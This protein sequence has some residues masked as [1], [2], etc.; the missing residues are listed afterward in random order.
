M[1]IAQPAHA[2]QR[3]YRARGAA[4]ITPYLIVNDARAAIAWYQDIL[5]ARVTYEPIIMDD[6]RIG[7]V[8]LDIDGSTIQMAD[9]FPDIGAVSP[10]TLGGSTISLSLYVPDC[11]ATF[12]RAVEAGASGDRPPADQF[13]G[14]RAASITDPFGHRWSLQTYMGADG[15]PNDDAAASG[16][17]GPTQ[18]QDL[19][20]EI[21]YYVINVPRLEA[22]R[23][24][25]G[26]LFGWTF[27]E[28]NPASDGPG[29]YAD[30][31][32]GQVPFVL[33]GGGTSTDVWHPHFR[34]RDLGE[35]V[36]KVRDLGG[37]VESENLYE[38][39]SNAVCVDDQGVRFELWQPADG[40]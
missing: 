21:G 4:A 33:H 20:N 22:A 28:S 2:A 37:T 26:G 39:G 14:A 40:Y 31:E 34:V 1:T 27:A 8:E 13:Y 36:A 25:W 15:E 38:S 12:A 6:G 19:W 10:Q 24:F 17:P 7:H 29:E 5:G 35:A 3:G 30:V 23:R 9:E 11:D 32:S 18:A 16:P